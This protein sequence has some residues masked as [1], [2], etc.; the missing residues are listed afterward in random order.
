MSCLVRSPVPTLTPSAAPGRLIGLLGCTA[1]VGILLAQ[2]GQRRAPVG[3][4]RLVPVRRAE[5]GV[6]LHAGT[7]VQERDGLLEEGLLL[8]RGGGRCV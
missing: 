2:G 4:Q 3:Q 7:L 6:P 1:A 8:G 5:V